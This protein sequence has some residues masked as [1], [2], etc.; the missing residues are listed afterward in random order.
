M[1]AYGADRNT[2]LHPPGPGPAAG[3]GVSAPSA[4]PGT[5]PGCRIDY[6]RFRRTAQAAMAIAGSGEA[7]RRPDHL[8]LEADCRPF[9]PAFLVPQERAERPDSGTAAGP[10][11]AGVGRVAEEVRNA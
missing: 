9:V 6:P 10:P 5:A 11:D 2:D 3:G 1:L 4:P 7:W 8:L